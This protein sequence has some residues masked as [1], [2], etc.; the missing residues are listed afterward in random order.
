MVRNSYLSCNQSV[1]KQ[2][3]QD[4]FSSWRSA[5]ANSNEILKEY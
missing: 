3:F 1:K 2:I 5:G 4:A